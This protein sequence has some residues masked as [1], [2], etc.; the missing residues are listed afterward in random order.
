[1]PEITGRCL[2]G[3][4]RYSVESGPVGAAY[5]QCRDCQYV[6][7]GMPNPVVVFSRAAFHWLGA[8]PRSHATMADS[9]AQVSRLFC[10]A[11]GSRIGAVNETLPAVIAICAGSL[12]DRSLFKP[13]VRIWAASA[14]SWHAID[15]S[16]PAVNGNP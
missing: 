3:A 14:P 4:I 6:N 9:G 16:L 7:G 8:E 5:C 12:D 10:D 11:C 15:P 13:G 2:C 1:M